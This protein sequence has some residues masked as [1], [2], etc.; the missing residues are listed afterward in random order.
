[1]AVAL[2]HGQVCRLR[3]EGAVFEAGT[4]SGGQR[5]RL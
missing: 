2:S 4:P 5:R 1:M 3:G